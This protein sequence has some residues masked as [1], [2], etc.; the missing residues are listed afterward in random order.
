[1]EEERT[2]NAKLETQPNLTPE[3]G[4]L[5]RRALLEAAVWMV[6]AAS[7][8]FLLGVLLGCY[9]GNSSRAIVSLQ[10]V[11]AAILLWA[12]LANRGWD[13]ASYATSTLTERVNEWIYRVSY[14]LGTALLVASLGWGYC[15]E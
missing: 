1:L 10:F 3:R 11:G 7:V 9:F 12:T 2:D 13:I 5:L 15:S 4:L 14:S 8:G 6:A